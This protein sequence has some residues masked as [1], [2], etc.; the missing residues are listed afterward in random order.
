M[1]AL[2]RTTAV[3]LVAVLLLAVPSLTWRLATTSA[4]GPAAQEGLL[5]LHNGQ[6]L[7]GRITRLDNRYGVELGEGSELRLAASDVD[8]V[9]GSLDEA[10]QRKAGRIRPGCVEDQL[11]FAEWCLRQGLIRQSAEATAEV[12]RAS[13]QEPRALVLERRLTA[14]IQPPETPPPAEPA[15]DAP[16]G[17]PATP[18]RLSS[19]QLDEALRRIGPAAI[20][21][22][23]TSVHP[24]L[25]NRCATAGC[26]GARA[27]AEYRLL[28]PPL[29]QSST[30]RLTQHNLL[31]TLAWLDP[32][33]PENSPLVVHARTSHG[34]QL[35]SAAEAEQ[36]QYEQL[37][38][39]VRQAA[40]PAAA[41]RPSRIEAS[42]PKLLQTRHDP[43]DAPPPSPRQPAVGGER[44]ASAA[45]ARRAGPQRTADRRFPGRTDA[46]EAS[47]RSAAATPADAPAAAAD[48]LED[49]FDPAV[50]NRRRK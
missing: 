35:R 22:F 36:R 25:L 44:E 6:V 43:L 17:S 11:D 29:G 49:P 24:L 45:D 7:R 30:R 13:P 14:L 1:P 50:F 3:S 46:S 10:C 31:A 9:A 26:H 5:V 32:D 8:F 42:A 27:T 16:A 19:L 15:L 39:W 41:A 4:Q 23:T 37:L 40:R 18:E 2:N 33:D 47:P 34:G 28:R 21:R 20:Q 12:L 38:D 48:P